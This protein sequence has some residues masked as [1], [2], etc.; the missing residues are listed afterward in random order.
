MSAWPLVGDTVIEKRIN[1]IMSE[2]FRNIY[3]TL[4]N[5]SQFPNRGHSG[6]N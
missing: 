2:S 6:Q 5:P 4:P 1:M 3:Q